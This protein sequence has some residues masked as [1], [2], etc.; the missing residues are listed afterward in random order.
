MNLTLQEV[1]A[2]GIGV[3]IPI[4][5]FFLTY[6]RDRKADLKE[7]EAEKKEHQQLHDIHEEKAKENRRDIDE[8]KAAISRL[9]DSMQKRK[10]EIAEVDKK[11]TE[12]Q[13]DI[14][15]KIG[16]L[17]TSIATMNKGIEGIGN[18]V[19]KIYQEMH[20]KGE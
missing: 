5:T 2:F 8:N 4:A 15:E 11:V 10:G 3:F 13:L 9:S 19:E 1:A 17:E 16:K 20:G 7:K 12:M 18:L 14:T 6:K